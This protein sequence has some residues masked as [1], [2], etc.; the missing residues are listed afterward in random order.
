MLGKRIAGESRQ[1]CNKSQV[2]AEVGHN[3]LARVVGCAVE[4]ARQQ[5]DHYCCSTVAD[6]VHHAV[7]GDFDFAA[8]ADVDVV[9][10]G[11]ASFDC[12]LDHHRQTLGLRTEED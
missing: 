10:Q 7:A 2:L 6:A 5:E 4:V 9:A 3:Y 8:E 1:V 11:W 12:E